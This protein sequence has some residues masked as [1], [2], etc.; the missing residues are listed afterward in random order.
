MP[1]LA[2]VYL[3]ESFSLICGAMTRLILHE[4]RPSVISSKLSESASVSLSRHPPGYH[5]SLSGPVKNAL[6]WTEGLVNDDA[7]YLSGRVFGSIMTACGFKDIEENIDE[8]VLVG[9]EC[10]DA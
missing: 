7:P 4:P 8:K 3:A 1:L 6:D 5:G 2:P 10:V 9:A